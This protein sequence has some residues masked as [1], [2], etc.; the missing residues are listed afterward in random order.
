MVIPF[1]F[2]S[3]GM[4]VHARFD[5]MALKVHA[6]KMNKDQVLLEVSDIMLSWVGCHQAYR[7]DIDLPSI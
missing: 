5:E 2:K 3:A 7:L 4:G 1:E 6:G